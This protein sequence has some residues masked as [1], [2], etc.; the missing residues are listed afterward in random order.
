M[1]KLKDFLIRM[2]EAENLKPKEIQKLT[3]KSQSVVYEW[4]NNSNTSSFPTY[5]SL[6]KILCRL[7]LTMD[8]FLKCKSDKLV[9]YSKYRTYANYL[10]SKNTE[11]FVLP[12]KHVTF[13]RNV[14]DAL[15][16]ENILN[17]YI[18]DCL[19]LKKMISLYLKGA[20]I[21]MEKFD[22]L[23]KNINPYVLSDIEFIDEYGG[24]AYYLNSGNIDDYKCRTEYYKE[25][26]EDDPDN[27]L[28]Y[29]HELFFPDADFFALTVATE[30]VKVLEK[31]LLIL[32]EDEKNN[33]MYNYVIC[34]YNQKDFDKNNQIFRFL[35]KN[36][37]KFIDKSDE[38]ITE[39]YNKIL[40]EVK[41]IKN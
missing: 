17:C 40:N 38:K 9:D 3:G 27:A 15:N 2:C 18:S 41:S 6:S 13:S 21:D 36:K 12:R 32:N 39:L 10:Y 1:I 25:L 19:D 16:Y 35:Y 11:P 20:K 23:C 26:I 8:E 28:E 30:N 4:L 7:G 37:C 14:M 29:S 31:Y 33:L 5:E 24:V 34:I 22:L